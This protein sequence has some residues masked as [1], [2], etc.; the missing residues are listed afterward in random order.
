MLGMLRG[1]LTFSGRFRILHLTWF[2]FFI[3]FVL[4]FNTAPLATA[5]RSDLGLN[6]KQIRTVIV[7]NLAL[8]IPARIIVGIL[9]DRYGPRKVF[10]AIL[11]YSIIPTL[12]CAM[13]QD[14]NQLVWS[15]IAMSIVGAG[16][17]V[18]IRMMSEWFPPKDVGFATGIYGGWG[19]AGATF[20]TLALPAVAASS[21]FLYSGQVNW[22]LPVAATGIFAA[23]YGVIYFFIAEDTPPGKVFERAHSAT[24]IEVTSQ[25]DFWLLLIM[26]APMVGALGILAWRLNIV[27]VISQS[28]LYMSY[29]LLVGLYLFQTY[30]CWQAN[31]DL[32]IG[33]KRYPPV[34]RYQFSQVVVLQLCYF[35]TIGSALA[36]VSMLPM[37]FE[38]N[39]GLTP[40]VAGLMAAVY[41]ACNVFSRPGGG[42]LSDIFNR[43]WTLTILIAGMG[44]SYLLMS[45]VDGNWRLPQAV[46]IVIIFAVFVQS[47]GGATYAIVPLIRKRITGQIAGNVGAYSNIAGICYLTLYSLLPDGNEGDRIY[48]QTLGI[49]SLIVAFVCMF[50][51]QQ[52]QEDLNLD[53]EPSAQIATSS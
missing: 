51:L 36:V 44:L 8:T 39:F 29:L 37:F 20:S 13:A 49:A 42:L 43:K 48:F 30:M 11:V 6:V 5:I 47:G 23:I 2:A 16:F 9:L 53:L 7:C 41:S 34:E 40:V 25:K 33:K 15:R 12:W 35:V 38:K 32:M 27:K 45:N 31:R 4:W 26:N 18:G 3:I 14:Y 19:N 1:L 28:Q 21:A 24:G 50:F 17:V 10:S 22:R 52:P 46:A